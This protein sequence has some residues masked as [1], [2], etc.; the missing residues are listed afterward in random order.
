[1]KP[2]RENNKDIPTVDM[3]KIPNWNKNCIL[4]NNIKVAAPIVV[5]APEMTES[6]IDSSM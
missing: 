5:I 3:M 6:P 1:V 2:N 4:A